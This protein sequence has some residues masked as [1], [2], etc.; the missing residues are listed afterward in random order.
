M[1]QIAS[2]FPTAGRAVSLGR[3]PGRARLGLGTAWFNLAGL[4]TVLAAINV[5]TFQF[6]ASSFWPDVGRR[7]ARQFVAV[8]AITL[9]R[10]SSTI[11]AFA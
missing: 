7:S 6:A 5:G 2:A 9:R 1:G 8:V 3:D 11:W 4:V 10:R